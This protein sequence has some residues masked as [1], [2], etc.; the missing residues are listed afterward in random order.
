MDERKLVLL[1]VSI[2]VD[3]LAVGLR[4]LFVCFV[5]VCFVCSLFVYM[6][7]VCVRH[8]C[9]VLELEVVFFLPCILRNV[10]N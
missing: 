5:L 8:V 4:E 9:T 2:F 6:V 7:I 1:P 3:L 10:F